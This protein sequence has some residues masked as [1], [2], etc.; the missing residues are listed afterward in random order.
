M[1]EVRA[2]KS[3]GARDKTFHKS[4][5]IL[6]IAFRHADI[7]FSRPFEVSRMGDEATTDRHGLKANSDIFRSAVQSS[8]DAQVVGL[9]R[10]S[11]WLNARVGPLVFL[12][13]RTRRILSRRGIRRTCKR[14]AP[15][16]RLHHSDPC[17][18]SSRRFRFLFFQGE[19]SF[20]RLE[21]RCRLQRFRR[22]MPPCF[23]DPIRS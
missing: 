20:P 15:G 8:Y 13:R 5:G 21:I 17:T 23:H 18:P 7:N 19:C 2:D 11:T 22:A 10:P 4:G 1:N 9:T 6:P 16:I 14:S 12:T 3:R